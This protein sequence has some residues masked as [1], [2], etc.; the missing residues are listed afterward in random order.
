[1]PGRDMVFLVS[2]KPSLLAAGVFGTIETNSFLITSR[3]TYQHVSP[4]SKNPLNLLDIE[5]SLVSWRVC[6][7][8]WTLCKEPELCFY[9]V[10]FINI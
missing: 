7:S 3:F 4:S 5:L 2:K 9:F 10:L 6:L 8:G 1:M